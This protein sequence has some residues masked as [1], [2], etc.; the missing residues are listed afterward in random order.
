LKE[1]ATKSG[2]P[3]EV[4]CASALMGREWQ[5]RLSSYYTDSLSGKPRELDILAH[6]QSTFEVKEHTYRLAV[7]AF[8]SCKGF[9]KQ[10]H[11]VTW[12][13]P[14][15]FAHDRGGLMCSRAGLIQNEM[16]DLS[17]A[18]SIHLVK[19]L[20][21]DRRLISLKACTLKPDSAEMARDR[22]TDLYEGAD[23]A[24]KAAS[25]WHEKGKADVSIQL[26]I[27]LVDKPI[28]DVPIDHVGEPGTPQ[29]VR[30]GFCEGFFP[31][32]GLGNGPAELLTVVWSW[33][34]KEDLLEMLDFMVD[35]ARNE[36]PH[37]AMKWTS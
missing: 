5:V 18:M 24:L 2:R 30:G 1:L 32:G 33:H 8:I 9:P 37:L 23:S 31:F 3:L 26:P 27:V 20:G 25:W 11:P 7:N 35:Q 21:T 34:Y 36:L 16:D 4:Q 13:I 6:K 19:K 15:N 17:A 29:E 14:E 10:S 22:D 12:S 28:I